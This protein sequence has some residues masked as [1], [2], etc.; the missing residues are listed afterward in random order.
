MALRYCFEQDYVIKTLNKSKKNDLAVID[1]DGIDP[2]IIRSAVA[3]GVH[4]YGYLNA[5]ALEKER[6]Y[7]NEFKDLRIAAYDG[8]PGEYWVDCTAEKWKKHLI[9]E[10]KKFKGMGI[11]GLYFDNTDLYYMCVKGFREKH[12]KMIKPAPRAWAVY[13][14]LKS[15]MIELE[16][17]S[18]GLIVMP[19]G[20]DV[21]VRKLVGNGWKHLIK[22]VNQESVLYS[23]NK[24]VSRDDTEYF[25]DYLDWCKEQGF[26]TRG[27]EYCKRLDQ[28][29]NAKAYYRRRGWQGIYI[30]KHH[31]LRGD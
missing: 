14:A 21:F 16:S 25:T 28:I 30:S 18:V 19:N 31:D 24:R 1:P 9:D 29:A 26:Y 2:K 6:S 12:T 10:A 4:V 3:R 8:W 27:I 22:T 7:Y 20:G 17:A 23:D 15:V 11:K 5:C 13:E